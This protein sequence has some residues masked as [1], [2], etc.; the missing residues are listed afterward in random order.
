M[1]AL[2]IRLRLKVQLAAVLEVRFELR[3]EALAQ[4]GG[5]CVLLLVQNALVLQLLGDGI[6]ALPGQRATQKVHQDVTEGLQI[7]ATALFAAQMCVDRGVAGSPG[8]IVS[9]RT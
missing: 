6:Q 2:V 1:H 9:L 8:Q 4:L 5:H 3:R 7:V